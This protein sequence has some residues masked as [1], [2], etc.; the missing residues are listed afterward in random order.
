MKRVWV[1]LAFLLGLGLGL[2]LGFVVSSKLE[3]NLD[4]CIRTVTQNTELDVRRATFLCL[5]R[6]QKE[7]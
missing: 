6:G 7:E 1:A 5:R 3:S 2:A 4:R